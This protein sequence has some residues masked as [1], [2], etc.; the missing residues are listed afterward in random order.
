V[1]GFLIIDLS[2]LLSNLVK[3]EHGGWVPIMMAVGVYVLMSTWKRGRMQLGAIQDAGASATTRPI[4]PTAMAASPAPSAATATSR[5]DTRRSQAT[6]RDV[7][8]SKVVARTCPQDAADGAD[9]AGTVADGTAPGVAA[10]GSHTVGST[11]TTPG[12]FIVTQA[13]SHQSSGRVTSGTPRSAGI[14][15]VGPL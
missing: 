5:R 10:P 8:S 9:G 7:H 13:G 15:C 4:V 12:D 1:G 6:C 3:I 14:G 2:F 11:R